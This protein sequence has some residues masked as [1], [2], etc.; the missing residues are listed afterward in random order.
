MNISAHPDYIWYRMD[1]LDGEKGGVAVV[2]RCGLDQKL[3]PAVDLLEVIGV[4]VFTGGSSIDF[5]SVYLPGSTSYRD[6]LDS[7]ANDIRKI[8]S[9]RHSYFRCGD[10]NSRNRLWNCQTSNRA[11]RILY[12][13]L[14]FTKFWIHN[15]PTHT[16]C[17]HTISD[18]K[19]HSTIYL[20]LT[21][22]LHDISQPVALLWTNFLR[23]VCG[24]FLM[25]IPDH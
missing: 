6:V 18:R 13:E 16:Y 19:T 1:R 23:S 24:S 7:N 5:Y 4:R 25:S 12:N 22:G 3:L 15:P 11:G 9:S 8:C 21:N 20:V 2:I 10:L 14:N 17:Q